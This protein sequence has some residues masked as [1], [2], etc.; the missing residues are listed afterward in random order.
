MDATKAKRAAKVAAERAV[1]DE[2]ERA[3]AAANR[4]SFRA[5]VAGALIERARAFADRNSFVA[6]VVR[7]ADQRAAVSEAQEAALRKVLDKIVAEAAAVAASG[8]VGTPGERITVPVTVAR[9]ATFERPSFRG[10]GN[11]TVAITTMRDAAGNAIVVKSATFRAEVGET[12][13]L[14]GT[15]K[16]HSEFR[17][18]KQTVVQRAT[19]IS[20]PVTTAADAA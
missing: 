1:K 8:W 9:V 17:G 19:V 15:V 16:E 10:F 4:E 11:E 3:R 18:E 12:F 6:D 5:T 20:T 7:Q 14:R 2:A 13:M